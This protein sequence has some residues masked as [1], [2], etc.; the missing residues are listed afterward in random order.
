MIRRGSVIAGTYRVERALSGGGMARVYLASGI[1]TGK[2]W[3]LKVVTRDG[4]GADEVEWNALREEA[5]LLKNLSHPGLVRVAD[6]LQDRK[7]R[8]LVTDYIEGATL[9]EVL[10][11]GGALPEHLVVRWMRELCDVTGYL[12]AQG[13]R[14]YDLK[15]ANLMLRPD[16]S[17][18]L[19][20]FGSAACGDDAGRIGTPWYAAPEQYRADARADERTDV[21]AIGRTMYALLAGG[22]RR[23]FRLG[24]VSRGLKKVIR[25]CTARA[26]KK[27]YR[28][29]AALYEALGRLKDA[30]AMTKL[31]AL[32]RLLLFA[33][34]A[35]Y[36]LLCLH[37]FLAGRQVQLLPCGIALAL[38]FSSFLLLDVPRAYLALTGFD[39]LYAER[40]LRTSARIN[41]VFRIG[42]DMRVRQAI[43]WEDV[44]VPLDEPM[45]DVRIDPDRGK[46]QFVSM[47]DFY[48][49]KDIRR[50]GMEVYDFE[51]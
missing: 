31:Y 24:G 42:R 4:S 49:E 7:C 27:R 39:V 12:H 15:P 32:I 23:L 46:V 18:A 11:A 48:I 5:K 20:D 13:I 29:V 14:H 17:I 36:A 8:I 25:C 1:G 38:A 22:R 26:P 37:G 34:V 43:D 33:V 30:P 19:I 6:F 50:D 51:G 28:S 40:R 2:K 3:V 16:G 21:Y 10:R 47:Q 35:V 45:T 9:E 44:M 41:G